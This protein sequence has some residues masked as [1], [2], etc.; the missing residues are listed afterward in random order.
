MKR[1]QIPLSG[2]I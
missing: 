2:E 1:F